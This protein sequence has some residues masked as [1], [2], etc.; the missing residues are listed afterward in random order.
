MFPSA[1]SIMKESIKTHSYTNLN[2]IFT[3]ETYIMSQITHVPSV[4]ELIRSSLLLET[5]KD[6][7]GPRCSFSVLI[8]RCTSVF[9]S[10]IRTWKS[11]KFH[12]KR[13]NLLV[14][15]A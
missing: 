7:T 4:H 13:Q 12:V 5:C 14:P 3:S 11:D 8:N 10:H 9:M 15:N 2:N 6:V 1:A